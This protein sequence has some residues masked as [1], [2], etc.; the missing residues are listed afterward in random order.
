[1]CDLVDA[2]PSFE[3]RVWRTM[4]NTTKQQ[5]MRRLFNIFL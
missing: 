5:L 2:P 4:P 3:T 1:M